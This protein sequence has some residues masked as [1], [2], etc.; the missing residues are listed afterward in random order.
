LEV[1]AYFKQRGKAREQYRV[2]GRAQHERETLALVA[3]TYD[4]FFLNH[5]HMRVYDGLYVYIIYQTALV[6]S[7]TKLGCC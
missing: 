1:V 4:A 5:H 6:E 3:R 7:I 2:E